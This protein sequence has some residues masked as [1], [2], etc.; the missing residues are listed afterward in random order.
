MLG[1]LCRRV[2]RLLNDAYGAAIPEGTPAF[3][4][5]IQ[6]FGDLLTWQPHIHALVADGAFQDNGV[7]RVLPPIPT[8]YLEQALREAVFEFLKGENCIDEPLI[9]KLRAWKHTG[10]SVHNGVRVRGSDGEG[11]KR[12]A[13]YMLRAPLSLDKLE[14]VAASGTVIYRSKMHAT[15]KRNFQVMPGAK[16]LEL[17]IA[18][19]PDKYEHL[20]RYY[21]AYSSRYRGEHQG[22]EEARANTD[23]SGLE[24][25]EPDTDSR[26]KARAAWAQRIYRVY[27]VDPLVCPRCGAEMRVIAVIHDAGVIRQILEHLKLWNP[28]PAQRGPPNDPGDS[29]DWPVN[30]QLPLTYHPVPDIA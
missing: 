27:E 18:H 16:W 10:F 5:F 12:L 9:D 3:I 15:L 6:T 29:P 21:G 28:R 13:R 7:F 30:A 24:I 8:D 22:E 4:L 2:A 26:R 20:V 23:D 25:V 14:Y 17:L 1:E 11:R 19:I